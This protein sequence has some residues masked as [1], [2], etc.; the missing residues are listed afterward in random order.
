[1][2]ALHRVARSI[3]ALFAV[4]LFGAATD[5]SAQTPQVFSGTGVDGA[6]AAIASFKAAIGGVDNGTVIGSQ[7]TGSVR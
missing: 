4:A 6:T 3:A 2:S 1:M 7:P 5:V